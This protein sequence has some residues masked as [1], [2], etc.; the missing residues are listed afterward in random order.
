M[1]VVPPYSNNKT[2]PLLQ[3]DDVGRGKNTIYNLPKNEFSYGKPLARDREGAKEG[4]RFHH[5]I[6]SDDDMEIPQREQR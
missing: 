3:R 5:F 6:A 1:Q 2:N 4:T